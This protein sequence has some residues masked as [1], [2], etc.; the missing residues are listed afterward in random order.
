MSTGSQRTNKVPGAILLKCQDRFEG[1][2]DMELAPIT[3]MPFL[4]VVGA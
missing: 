1:L 4:G 2:L 3:V